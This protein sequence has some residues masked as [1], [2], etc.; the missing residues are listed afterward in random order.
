LAAIDSV[1]LV[2]FS[3]IIV[4]RVEG[5]RSW[6]LGIIVAKRSVL[7]GSLLIM[8]RHVRHVT[9]S[10]AHVHLMIRA[11]VLLVRWVSVYLA[12]PA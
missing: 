1:E 7:L 11:C 5:S 6:I 4:R 12:R 8:G 10:V 3:Q 9:L 2:S